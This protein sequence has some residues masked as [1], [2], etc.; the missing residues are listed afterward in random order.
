MR[1]GRRPN[2]LRRRATAIGQPSVS[3][4]AVV[5]Q[6]QTSALKQT[7]EL[8]TFQAPAGTSQATTQDFI[9]GGLLPGSTSDSFSAGLLTPLDP[10]GGGV[11]SSVSGDGGASPA[12]EANAAEDDEDGSPTPQA[13]VELA[14]QR[15]YAAKQAGRNRYLGR[16]GE[17]R[18]L[19]PQAA[20][21][22]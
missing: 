9:A 7:S 5:V 10:S 2:G 4:A 22:S 18:V 15:K 17:A 8:S 19:L 14:D 11:T 20:K 1:P 3:G 16:P 12:T 13:L 21:G 6:Q